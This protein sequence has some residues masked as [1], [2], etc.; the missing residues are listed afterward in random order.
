VSENVSNGLTLRELRDL[1]QT[2]ETGGADFLL[3]IERWLLA[4]PRQ[5]TLE[6]KRR[7][8]CILKR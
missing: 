8:R 6:Q 3:G 2:A 5:L 1:E 7:I 4:C